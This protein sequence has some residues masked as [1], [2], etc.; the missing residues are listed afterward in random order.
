MDREQCIMILEGY[1]AGSQMVQ[2]ICGF[3]RNAIIVCCMAGNYSTAF[4]AGR[5]ITQGGPLS[6]KLFNILLDAVVRKW[7]RQL[8]EDGVYEE[9]KL[10]ALTSTFFA[11]FYVNNAYLA[12]RDAGFLQHALTLLVNLFEHVGLQTNTSKTQT[13]ICTPGRIQ[14]QLPTKSYRLMQRGM[15]T[16]AEWNSRDVHCYQCRKRDEGRLLWPPPGRC[17]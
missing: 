2:L 16:A 11:I 3:W 8:E 13:M 15:V 4:K 9:G 6:A 14:T 17:P 12:S 10:A 1:G 5:G 7:V